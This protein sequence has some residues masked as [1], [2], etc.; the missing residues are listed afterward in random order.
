MTDPAPRN[1]NLVQGQ[2][3]TPDS[4]LHLWHP[5][6]GHSSQ[7]LNQQQT[8]EW[9]G[10]QQ[11]GPGQTQETKNILHWLA[12]IRAGETVWREEI[13][14]QWREEI[15]QQLSWSLCST[16]EGLVSE[17]ENQVEER[18][19][20]SQWSSKSAHE[21]IEIKFFILP[22]T[23]SPSLCFLHWKVFKLFMAQLCF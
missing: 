6:S 5:G 14:Q 10:H 12:N 19:V 16:S 13:H 18:G 17:Q 22:R 4:S 20:H 23:N 11:R 1:H 9:A 3:R 15:I 21:I 2:W 7:P 8:R